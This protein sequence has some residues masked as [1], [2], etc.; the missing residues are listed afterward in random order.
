MYR[1]EYRMS[2][3]KRPGLPGSYSDSIARFATIA[4]E[5]GEQSPMRVNWAATYGTGLC[6]T[7]ANNLGTWKLASQLLGFSA[8]ASDFALWNW[9]YHYRLR[10]KLQSLLESRIAILTADVNSDGKV[11]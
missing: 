4:E 9:T 2:V 3:W 6:A 5:D 10:G 8:Q 11:D 1:G 7:I